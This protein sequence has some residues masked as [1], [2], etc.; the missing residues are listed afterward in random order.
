MKY[1]TRINSFISQGLNVIETIEQL[2]QIKGITHVD[3]NYPEHFTE[4]SFEEIQN[5]LTK[6][7]IRLNSI[8]LRFREEFQNGEYANADEA[9]NKK[10]IALTKE[11]IDICR[12]LGGELI[13]IWLGY[14]GFDYPFQQNYERAWDKIV[15]AFEEICVYADD[16]KVSIE[17]KPYQPRVF[18]MVSS[19]GDTMLIVQEAGKKNLGMTLDFCHM[20]MKGENPA[21]VLALTSRY[22]KLYGIHL[23]DGNK[24]NDDGLMVGTINFAQTVEF[25]YYLKKAKYDGVI[26]FDTFPVRE[27][28]KEETEMNI[29]MVNKIE[30]LIDNVGLKSIQDVI[31]SSNSLNAQKLLLSFLK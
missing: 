23:N 12:R 21:S 15:E 25:I 28:A 20:I 13:T 14:D 29:E 8:A 1:A 3:L 5:A 7:G 9:I 4:F 31:D 6:N 27:K 30:Q 18:S 22:D 11:G 26:Y 10:A 24:L 2:S 19:F 16:I 17:Y